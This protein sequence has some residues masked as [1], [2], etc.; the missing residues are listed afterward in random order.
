M[1]YYFKSQFADAIKYRHT[2]EEKMVKNGEYLP[3]DLVDIVLDYTLIDDHGIIRLLDETH[4]PHIIDDVTLTIGGNYSM[5]IVHNSASSY[6]WSILFNFDRGMLRITMYVPVKDVLAYVECGD[7]LEESITMRTIHETFAHTCADYDE[8]IHNGICMMRSF[9]DYCIWP[10]NCL[11]HPV[12][13]SNIAAYRACNRWHPITDPSDSESDVGY[14][15][16]HDDR[17]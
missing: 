11:D 12:K 2:A 6:E 10:E 14:D 5:S 9:F 1:S 17:E 3:D 7:I 8:S 16:R 4:L 13:L 15:D